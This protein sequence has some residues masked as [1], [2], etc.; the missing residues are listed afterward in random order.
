MKNRKPILMLIPIALFF[1]IGFFTMT[2]W[3]ILIPDLFGIKAITYWQAI[4]LFTL[5]RILFG[6]FRIGKRKPPFSTTRQNEKM[7]KMTDEE[8]L[9]LTEE[10]KKRCMK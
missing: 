2:L 1:A 4:G 7:M 5:S 10:L 8:R 6:S 3:N 9:K